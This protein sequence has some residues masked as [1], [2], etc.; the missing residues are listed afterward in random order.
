MDQA[1][2]EVEELLRVRVAR[3]DFAVRVA[4]LP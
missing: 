2:V 3:G 1:E 4:G